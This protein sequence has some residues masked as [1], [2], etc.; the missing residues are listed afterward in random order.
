MQ[1]A[2]AS[3]ETTDSNTCQI[4]STGC[5]QDVTNTDW[6]W[7]QRKDMAKTVTTKHV[8]RFSPVILEAIT[9]L[10]QNQKE[11]WGN[12]DLQEDLDCVNTVMQ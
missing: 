1:I 2:T 11:E 9:K 5:H 10:E 3:W 8:C 6:K 4:Y 7:A 12:L